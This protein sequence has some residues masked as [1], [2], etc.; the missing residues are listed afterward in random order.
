MIDNLILGLQTAVSLDNLLFCFIGVVLGTIIGMIPGVGTLATLSL[1][2]PITY[3]MSDPITALIMMSGIYYGSQY[4]GSITSILMNLPGEISSVVSVKDGYALNQQG[5][6][7]AALGV[8]GIGSFFAGSMATLLIIFLSPLLVKFSLLFGPSEYFALM[9][10]GLTCASIMGNQSVIKGL[11]MA[12]VGIMIGIIGI[13]PNTGEIRYIFNIWELAGGVAFLP[14]VMGLYGLG[15]I[16][17]YLLHKKNNSTIK[18]PQIK[19]FTTKT[20]KKIASAWQSILRGSILGS[21][22]GLIPGAGATLSSF[23]SY[24]VEKRIAKDN[25]KFGKGDIRGIA[26]PESANNAGAQ[27]SFIPMLSLGL[28]IN[29]VM[30]LLMSTM[31]MHNVQPG[32]GVITN[33]PELFW[34]LIMSMFIGNIFLLIINLGSISLLLKILKIPMW[35]IGIIVIAS[36]VGGVY[37]VD[38]NFFN[39]ILLLIF[40]LFGYLFKKYKFDVTALLLGFLLGP[41]MEESFRQV[42]QISYGNVYELFSSHISLLFYGFSLLVICYFIRKK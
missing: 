14:M 3:S 18:I 34:G 40:G 36:C 33:N 10:F 12:C 26:G 6:A 22:V 25:S 31:I 9:F 13:E 8:A 11:L 7:G 4:G 16:I 28:P 29:P 30:A 17:Y 5:Y 38:K 2:L 20:W 32:P 19:M 1:L 41:K 24:A 15:E 37:F 42:L 27:T 39:V 21:F 23:V 35:I